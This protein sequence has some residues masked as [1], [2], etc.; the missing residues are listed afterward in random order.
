MVLSPRARSTAADVARLLACW[1]AVILLLQGIGAA[2][3]LGRGPFHRHVESLGSA[4]HH[5]DA[6]QRHHHAAHDLSVVVSAEGTDATI[7]A[8]AFALVAALALMA[9]ARSRLSRDTRRHVWRAVCAWSWQTH[10]P[11]ALR[12]PPRKG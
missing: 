9:S 5:H 4:W 12:K 6:S 3:A 2:H 10:I 8:G 7:D 1:L 11:A